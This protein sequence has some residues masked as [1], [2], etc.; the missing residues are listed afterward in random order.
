MAFVSGDRRRRVLTEQMAVG[1][2]GTET[3]AVGAG[4]AADGLAVP[5]RWRSFLAA[6]ASVQ[7]AGSLWPVRFYAPS[8]RTVLQSP[9]Q[10]QP[11]SRCLFTGRG[12]SGLHRAGCRLT[13][14]RRE[15]TE[16]GTES[17]T[18][19]GRA[20]GTGKGEKVALR[21]GWL[22]TGIPV[23]AHRGRGNT[24]GRL[25]PIRSKIK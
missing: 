24:D 16:S 10:S 4:A 25:N 19:D 20:T 7:P 12:K 21:G 8:S 11:D 15:A 22:A 18:A 13:T 5:P 14:G 6:R 1:T 3:A 2:A 17:R 9:R 23:R